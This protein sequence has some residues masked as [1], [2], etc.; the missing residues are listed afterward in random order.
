[1]RDNSMIFAFTAEF[2]SLGGASVGSSISP[3]KGMSTA[4]NVVPIA[5]DREHGFALALLCSGVI[6]LLAQDQS[7]AI[8]AVRMDQRLSAM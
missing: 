6:V 1:M 3:T 4:L 5:L 7:V 2:R 8:V